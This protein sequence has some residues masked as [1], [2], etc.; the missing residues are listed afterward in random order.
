MAAERLLPEGLIDIMQCLVC[1]G[2][3]DEDVAASQLVCT[4]CGRRYPV[5]DGTPVML[6]EAV[7]MPESDG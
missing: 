2:T 6:A 3:L 5:E 1:A 7:I 4:S